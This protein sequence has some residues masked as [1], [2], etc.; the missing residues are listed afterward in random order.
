MHAKLQH[1]AASLLILAAAAWLYRRLQFWP[2]TPDGLFHLHR[3]RALVEA[4]QQGVLYPRWFPDFAFG[5]GHPIFNFYAPG[6]YPF[7]ALPHWAGLDIL[8]ANRLALCILFALS[9]LAAYALLYRWTSF[10]PALAGTALFLFFPYR[11]YDLFTRGALPEFAAF[12]WPPLI[13]FGYVA[14]YDYLA[15]HRSTLRGSSTLSRAIAAQAPWQIFTAL[16]WTG[17]ILTH[18]LTALMAGIVWLV[19]GLCMVLWLGI[20]PSAR[21]ASWGLVLSTLTAPLLLGGLLSGFYIMPVFLETQ[22]VDIGSGPSAPGYANHAVEWPTGL[23]T[24]WIDSHAGE[25][26]AS[27]LWQLAPLYIYPDAAAPTVA[28]PV[29][30]GILILACALLVW[31]SW[32]KPRR[33]RLVATLLVTL[34]AIWL[35]TTASL[36]LWDLTAP[37]LGKLQF[38]W[39]WQTIIALG[40]A[41]LVSL[42]LQILLWRTSTAQRR[43][44][45]PLAGGL[46]ALYFAVYSSMG[47]QVTPAAYTSADVTPAQMWAFDFEHGQIGATWTGEFLPTWV[48]A[49]RWTI[50]R[51]PEQSPAAPIAPE[52]LTGASLTTEPII[53]RPIRLSYQSARYA[54][55]TPAD[56]RFTLPHFYYPAWRATLNGAPIELAPATELGWI[57][58]DIPPGEQLLV[59]EWT[60]T[61]AVWV[62]RILS[63]SGWLGVA[64]LLWMAWWT[65]SRARRRTLYAALWACWVTVALLALAGMTN[66]P[67]EFGTQARAPAP[68]AGDF[69]VIHLSAAEIPAPF[70]IAPDTHPEIVLHWTAQHAAHNTHENTG[71]NT[72]ENSLQPLHAFVH[73]VDASG[74]VIAQYD[75][76]IGGNYLPVERHQPGL[77]LTSRHSFV[78]PP[79]LPS[80]VYTALAG[81]YRAGQA[82]QPLVERRTN[83]PRLPIGD[84]TILDG[85]PGNVASENATLQP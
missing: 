59:L 33:A 38:P 53:A 27:T 74:A 76:R 80:G 26:S 25:S 68:R 21:P 5:Y 42:A 22:W 73:L 11:L 12:L 31:T 19:T 29:Y 61:P 20:Y 52:S 78:L 34:L 71:E 48:H 70:V 69:G 51:A 17:L 62:G 72:G 67:A 60:A 36:W 81:V 41:I 4:W 14:S 44:L 6:Y 58:A 35:T 46:L 28:L 43:I 85:T 50:G 3:V 23:L 10:W 66:L 57:A 40:A 45:A 55:H 83:A 7:A 9:G 82:D 18:N 75:T 2:D 65:A 16:A 8:A 54:L 64:G 49:P 79:E 63:G 37:I 1:A 30:V 77:P 84:L 39:R 56:L 15:R 13:L 47:L 24:G 32:A